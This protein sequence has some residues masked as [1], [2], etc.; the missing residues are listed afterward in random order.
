[1]AGSLSEC[2]FLFQKSNRRINFVIKV[3][4]DV[5]DLPAEFFHY[6][7]VNLCLSL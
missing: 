7:R 3:L 5:F 1:M 2:F 4:H 6:V